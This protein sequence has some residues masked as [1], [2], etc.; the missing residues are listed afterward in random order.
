MNGGRRPGRGRVL[1]LEILGALVV[2]YAVAQ[3]ALLRIFGVAQGEDLKISDV[4]SVL[5]TVLGILAASVGLLVYV[6]A[7]RSLEESNRFSV[8]Q[9]SLGASYNGAVV[10]WTQLEPLLTDPISRIDTSGNVAVD[11]WRKAACLRCI[12]LGVDACRSAQRSFDQSGPDLEGR[13]RWQDKIRTTLAFLLACDVYVRDSASTDPAAIEALNLLA[14][15][16][17]LDDPESAAWI[18]LCCHR[19][20]SAAWRAAA[21]Y[22]RDVIDPAQ[23]LL[24]RL[25]YQAAFGGDFFD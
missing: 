21:T 10:A 17:D 18:R 4:I 14:K 12:E 16:Q 24:T 2:S 5:A 25:R 9:A 15:V 8:Q 22:A 11:E 1:A 7:R 23:D 6:L 20:G 19:R 13:G 3:P